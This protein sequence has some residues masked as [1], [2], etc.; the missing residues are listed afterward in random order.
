MISESYN[1]HPTPQRAWGFWC[2]FPQKS[3]PGDHGIY[4]KLFQGSDSK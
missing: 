1:P 2:D 4:S 3:F